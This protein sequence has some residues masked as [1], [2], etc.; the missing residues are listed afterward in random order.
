M[1][2]DSLRMVLWFILCA[3]MAVGMIIFAILYGISAYLLRKIAWK[4][5][6][7]GLPSIRLAK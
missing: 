2:S 1:F 4:Q 7:F 3:V 5:L 6:N